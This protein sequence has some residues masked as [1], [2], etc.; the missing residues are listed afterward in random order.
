MFSVAE[1]PK[2]G[3]ID[4]KRDHLILN[5]GSLRKAM[6]FFPGHATPNYQS[7]KYKHNIIPKTFPH[8]LTGKEITNNFIG[9]YTSSRST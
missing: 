7:N 8:C 5:R 3:R 4:E 2:G 6:M 9:A 1:I